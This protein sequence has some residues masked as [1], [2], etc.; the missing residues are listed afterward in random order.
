MEPTMNTQNKYT[1]DYPMPSITADIA[2][3]RACG[4]AWQD[5]YQILLIKRKY[6]PFKDCW[7][8]PGGFMEINETLKECAVR[9]LQEETGISPTFPL[10]FVGLAD[11]P[12]RDPR[13]RIVSA[14]F[15]TFVDKDTE[16]IPS[17]DAVEAEWFDIYNL[18][19]MAFDHMDSINACIDFLGI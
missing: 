19:E 10:Q 11:E 15:T 14:T 5:E 17:D 6:P 9:E 18:P 4:A 12:L 13:G 3:F 16:A 8:L 2:V 1:Y 7:A